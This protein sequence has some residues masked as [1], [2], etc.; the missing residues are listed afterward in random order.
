[1]TSAG[2]DRDPSD[3]DRATHD[4]SAARR[5]GHDRR[6]PR[7]RRRLRRDRRRHDRRQRGLRPGLR[8]LRALLG[9]NGVADQRPL[10]GARRRAALLAHRPARRAPGAPS[11]APP[12]LIAGLLYNRPDWI[13]DAGR[14]HERPAARRRDLARLP[15]PR[16]HAV[17]GRVR[18]HRSS[19][20]T[21]AIESA[22][23]GGSGDD[24]IAGGAGHDTI[25]GGLGDD[26]IQGDAGI[27]GPRAGAHRA[28]AADGGVGDLVVTAVVRGRERRRR[29]RRGRRRRRR[30]L[31]RPRP[32]RPDRRQLGVLRAA[33]ARASVRTATT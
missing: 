20:H 15:Q 32:G 21:A 9:R 25:F 28:P 31:R 13:G 8:R 30:D 4:R 14:R 17:V 33:H 16:R 23:G 2:D 27:D 11:G 5:Q 24:Y 19:E 1:M 6:R 26:V 29:L 22:G 10:P 7:Q 18:D 3:L 12:G